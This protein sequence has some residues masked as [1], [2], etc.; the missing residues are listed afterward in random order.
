M[1]DCVQQQTYN[2]LSSGRRKNSSASSFLPA[3]I[4]RWFSHV[5]TALLLLRETRFLHVECLLSPGCHA[6]G[7]FI[8]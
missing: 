6:K 3:A 2:N 8:R 5:S 4:W 7:P 1:F